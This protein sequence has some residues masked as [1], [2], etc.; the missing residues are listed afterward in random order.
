MADEAC[1]LLSER[2]MLMDKEETIAVFTR[3]MSEYLRCSDLTETKSF[4]RS[5]VK[6]I[7]VRP[8]RATIRY[9]LPIPEE[10]TSVLRDASDVALRS[11]A[12]NTV[13]FRWRNWPGVRRGGGVSRLE[14]TEGFERR[15]EAP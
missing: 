10:G 1:R 4:I 5:F 3:D 6:E 8:G 13:P 11:P 12:I 7:A 9:T 2:R 15:V 14:R